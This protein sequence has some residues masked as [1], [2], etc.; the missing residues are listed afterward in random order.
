MEHQRFCFDFIFIHHILS[1]SLL[2]P[3]FCRTYNYTN[4]VCFVSYTNT[5]GTW[6]PCC[7][8]QLNQM[9]KINVHQHWVTVTVTHWWRIECKK[10][11]QAE[12]WRS[13]NEYKKNR[14]IRVLCFAA[15]DVKHIT[16][17]QYFSYLFHFDVSINNRIEC[18]THTKH[19]FF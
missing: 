19:T 7:S 14:N 13:E 12:M 2:H 16:I 4:H 17:E 15:I 18:Q 11:K 9:K 3:L 8:L 1:D 5:Y 6:F 10:N